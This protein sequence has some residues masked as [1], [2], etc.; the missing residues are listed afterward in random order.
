MFVISLY[1]WPLNNPSLDEQSV[2]SLNLQIVTILEET[3]FFFTKVLDKIL[4]QRRNFY[5]VSTIKK[6]SKS[7]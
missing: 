3:A 7:T 6:Y 1:E 2:T 4:S 5:L